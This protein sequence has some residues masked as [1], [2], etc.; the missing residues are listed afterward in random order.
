MPR[1]A[2]FQVLP[3][4]AVFTMKLEAELRDEFMAEAQ[5]V[6]R[7]AS[8]VVRDLMREFVRRQR[9][10]RDQEEFLRSKVEAGRRDVQV[11]RV[12]A[13][14]EVEAD[15]AERRSSLLRKAGKAA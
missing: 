10:A 4:E 13:H 14:A 5:A 3:R 2:L 1:Y 6:D 15:F 9:E 11:G 8:Q 7:P 12:R